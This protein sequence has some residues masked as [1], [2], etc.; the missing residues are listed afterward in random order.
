MIVHRQLI[1]T[2]D[3]NSTLLL[4]MLLVV[5]RVPGWI[6][7]SRTWNVLSATHAVWTLIDVFH[8]RVKLSV[9]L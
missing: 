2:S 8:Y 3:T 5:M 7:S 4:M 1:A 9:R 6:V